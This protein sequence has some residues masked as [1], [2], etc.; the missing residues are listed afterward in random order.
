MKV[1]GNEVCHAG[2]LARWHCATGGRADL[3]MGLHVC[4]SRCL[5]HG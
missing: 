2:M 4:V 1:C 3:C 5:M